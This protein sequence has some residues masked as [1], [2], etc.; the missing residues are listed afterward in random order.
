MEEVDWSTSPDVGDEV[1][2]WAH[3]GRV[4]VAVVRSPDYATGDMPPTEA[5][6]MAAALLA[7]A[8]EAERSGT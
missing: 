5:R 7:A 4:W 6:A 3:N 8:D 1:R 2:V